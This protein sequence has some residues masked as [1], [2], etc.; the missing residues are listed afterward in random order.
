MIVFSIEA[1]LKRGM[2]HLFR[3]IRLSKV[4]KFKNIIF[5]IN[6]HKKSFEILR[7]NKVK[8]KVINYKK[9]DSINSFLKK[10]KINLWINDRLDTNFNYSQKISKKT[11]FITFDDLGKGAKFADYNI[12]PLIFGKKIQGKKILQGVKYLPLE[13]IKKK[14]IRKRNKVK[15]VL[16]SMGGSD[17]QSL[18]S[19]I[20]YNLNLQN[21][22]CTIL[23]GPG[24]KKNKI[25]S[26]NK[27]FIIKKN[28]KNIYEE[29]Y[30]H[31]LL[32]CGGG[33]TP[34]EA[35]TTGLPSIVIAT[36]KFEVNVGKK[37]KKLGIS[38][39]AGYYKDIDFKKLNLDLDI[40]KLSKNCLKK[41]DTKGIDR[42]S[43]IINERI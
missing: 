28:V 24:Q 37:L 26:N 38:K 7:E 9:K 42:I 23:L 35:A 12:C 29:F 8:F 14:Y 30:K 32:I 10:S 3:S 15:K 41:L 43:K 4:L 36:E 34:F 1:S 19:K 39:Y 11:S 5:L 21:I 6:N 31:D 27:K 2:G 40:L 25:S 18:N 16:I 13:K 33:M 22:H 20:I 17:T